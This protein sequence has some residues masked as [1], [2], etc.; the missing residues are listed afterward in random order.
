MPQELADIVVYSHEGNN[1]DDKEI[2][3][4]DNNVH[5]TFEA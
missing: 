2:P 3:E 4:V 1:E 5:L